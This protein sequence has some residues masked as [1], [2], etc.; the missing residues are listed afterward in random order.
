MASLKVFTAF[1]GS[2]AGIGS[3]LYDVSVLLLTRS[4]EVTVS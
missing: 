2:G 3:V 4:C 1:G